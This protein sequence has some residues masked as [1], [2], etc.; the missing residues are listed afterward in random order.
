MLL[1]ARSI[2]SDTGK[3]VLYGRKTTGLIK[4]MEL[5][6]WAITWLWLR[7]YY[8]TYAI[9]VATEVKRVL[10]SPE[11]FKQGSIF[12]IK[13]SAEKQN[14]FVVQDGNYLS[15][16]WPGDCYTLAQRFVDLLN[17]RA[18]STCSTK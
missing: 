1:L 5:F 13:D 18:V 6:A 11:D 4:P 16:R 9:S 2:D 14:G 3:S 17:S 12:P 15:G 10:K 8:R 7:N